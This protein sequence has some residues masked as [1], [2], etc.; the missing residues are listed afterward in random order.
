M[1]G[2]FSNLATNGAGQNN[3]AD[4][5]ESEEEAT[6]EKTPI[7]SDRQNIVKVG[8]NGSKSQSI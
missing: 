7:V 3:S 4:N 6:E 2:I 8:N 1:K 5:S